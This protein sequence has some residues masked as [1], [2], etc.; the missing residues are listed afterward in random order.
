MRETVIQT[1]LD[2]RIIAIV[3]GSIPDYRRLAQ[4]L[5]DGG[6]RAVEV[7][8]DQANPGSAAETAAAIHTLREAMD[9]KMAV[10]AGTIT[11][12]RLAVLA[13]DAGAEFIVTPNTNPAVIETARAL[14]MA[15]MPGALT[16][17]EIL[18]AYGYGADFVKIFPASA[19]GPAYIKAI[20]GPINHIPLLAVGGIS[21]ANIAAFL[22]AGCTGAG[23]GG[24][25]VNRTW[26]QAGEFHRI[27]ALAASLCQNAV[28]AN[29]PDGKGGTHEKSSNIR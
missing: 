10:G 21:E 24:N 13:R 11:S 5:F 9:R 3:R 27:T 25:L 12:P 6:I 7:T 15:V 18:Q 8:F 4:A 1:V 14:D 17:S 19:L 22:S 28:A 2:S 20:R 26:I 29:E 16:P 23:V